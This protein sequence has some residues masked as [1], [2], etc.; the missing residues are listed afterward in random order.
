MIACAGIITMRNQ[1][2][3][4]N[5]PIDPP[6]SVACVFSELPS[7]WFL[8]QTHFPFMRDFGKGV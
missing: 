7:H 3:P 1:M 4:V 8:C 2:L 5:I 6:C